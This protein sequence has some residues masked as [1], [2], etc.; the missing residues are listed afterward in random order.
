MVYVF[1]GLKLALI[2]FLVADGLFVMNVE[3]VKTTAS[4]TAS[5][6]QSK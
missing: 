4:I 5:I 2:A 6:Q 1:Y 3:Q